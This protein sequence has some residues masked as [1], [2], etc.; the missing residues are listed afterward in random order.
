[1]KNGFEK[2]S[3]MSIK[4]FCEHSLSLFQMLC[5]LSLKVQMP[6]SSFSNN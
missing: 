6:F 2:K 5:T 4:A 3:D 1:M